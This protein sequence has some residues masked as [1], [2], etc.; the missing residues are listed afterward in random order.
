MT[1]PNSGQLKQTMPP[2]TSFVVIKTIITDTMPRKSGIPLYQWHDEVHYY[3][4]DENELSM[5]DQL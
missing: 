2:N 3:D 5:R 4:E 1:I